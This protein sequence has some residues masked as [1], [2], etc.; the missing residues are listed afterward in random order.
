MHNL[1][2]RATLVML[3]LCLFGAMSALW[4]LGYM[5]AMGLID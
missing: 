2:I 1:V 5:A 4:C 3:G